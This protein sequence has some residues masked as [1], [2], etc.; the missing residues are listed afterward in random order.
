L[1]NEYVEHF[2]KAKYE[3]KGSERYINK[4]F[5]NG[6]YGYFGR[7]LENLSIE[8]IP[9]NQV[10]NK[11][12][13]YPS[14][15][16]IEMNNDT[17]LIL[18]DQLPS[19]EFLKLQNITLQDYY[20]MSNEPN[21]SSIVLTNVAIASAITSY[22]RIHIIP[23]K[24]NVNYPCFYTDTDS[25]F[26]QYPLND[27]LIGS[28][29]GQFKDKLN[30]ETITRAIFLNN[31]FYGYET[32]TQSKTV[33][34]GVPTKIIPEHI[35]IIN[36]KK[37]LIKSYKTSEITFEELIDIKN[38]KIIVKTRNNLIKKLLHSL[39]LFSYSSNVNIEYNVNSINKKSVFNKDKKLV[40]Y[41]P[42]YIFTLSKLII[43]NYILNQFIYKIN[44]NI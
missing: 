23:V 36:N 12:R 31:K 33:I 9:T 29:L 38:G 26:T 18:H 22:A 32:P 42:F 2:Y 34:S 28:G 41:E 20:K 15:E 8:F 3:S 25:V 44:I 37:T 4:L 30:G 27:N 14:Y 7:S 24:T 11:I 1:F 10:I 13:I 5:L 40:A 16:W 17:S 6:L 19:K 35:K 39:L 21:K 43:N